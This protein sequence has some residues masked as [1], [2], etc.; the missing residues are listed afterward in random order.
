MGAPIGNRNNSKG[1]PITDELRK[2]IVQDDW[3][4]VRKGIQKILDGFAAG[5]QWAVN[6]VMDRLEGKANATVDVTHHDAETVSEQQARIMAE[7][8]LDRA[9]RTEKVG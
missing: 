1:K 2:A 6:I 3:E 8:Y 5:E 7:A 4:R 9:A